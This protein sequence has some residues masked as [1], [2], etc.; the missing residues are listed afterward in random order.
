RSDARGCV[1]CSVPPGVLEERAGPVL[2]RSVASG[3]GGSDRLGK[4]CASLARIAAQEQDL[5]GV[6]GGV[7]VARIE[8]GG[9]AIQLERAIDLARLLRG[10]REPEHERSMVGVDRFEPFEDRA[11]RGPG[12]GVDELDAELGDRFEVFASISSE[13]LQRT[14][15]RA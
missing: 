1:S 8:A 14:S 9:A 13:R 5:G 12:S 11:R 10:E 15:A 7:S 6:G 4:E 2:E 3:G